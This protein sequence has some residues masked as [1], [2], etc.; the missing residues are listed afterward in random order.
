MDSLND[1]YTKQPSFGSKQRYYKPSSRTEFEANYVQV[2]ET[3]ARGRYSPFSLVWDKLPKSEYEA[4][5]AFFDTHSGDSF[6]WTHPITGTTHTVVFKSDAV[7][8]EFVEPFGY[9]KVTIEL[10]EL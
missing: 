7:E 6:Y 2:G 8:G 5:E 1:C 9:Y 3:A 4:I 10:E